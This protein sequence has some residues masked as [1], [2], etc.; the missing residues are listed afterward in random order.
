MKNLAA[1]EEAAAAAAVATASATSKKSASVATTAPLATGPW[2]LDELGHL[3]RAAHKF[4]GGF[5]NRWDAIQTEL[6]HFGIFRSLEDVQ[7]TSA[8]LKKGVEAKKVVNDDQIKQD[9]K[10]VCVLLCIFDF[11]FFFSF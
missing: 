2:S 11:D 1:Q 6:R 5:T 7:K 9:A 8:S 10:K 4:P 3:A